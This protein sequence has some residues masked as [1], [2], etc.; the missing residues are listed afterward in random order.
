MK[1]TTSDKIKKLNLTGPVDVTLMLDGSLAF[2]SDPEVK[3]DFKTER[4][5]IST[6][7]LI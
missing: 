5:N 6:P 4:S 7:V 2:G 3:V 1:S